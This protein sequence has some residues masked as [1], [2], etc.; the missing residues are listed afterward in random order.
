MSDGARKLSRTPQVV[1][2]ICAHN[3]S[4][5][6]FAQTLETFSYET[7]TQ[8][9]QTHYCLFSG[10]ECHCGHKTVSSGILS[11]YTTINSFIDPFKPGR[12]KKNSAFNAINENI[13]D[14]FDTN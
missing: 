7:I 13:N 9:T 10:D 6:I 4:V 3:F 11:K 12:N 1:N 5:F 2:I 8:I 14:Q